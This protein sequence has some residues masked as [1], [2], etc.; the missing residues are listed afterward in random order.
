MI[1][2]EQSMKTISYFTSQIPH[3]LRAAPTIFIFVAFISALVIQNLWTTIFFVG[4]IASC[5]LNGFL[6]DFVARPLYANFNRLS[7]PIIL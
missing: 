5:I 1:L 4:I 3:V 7:L 2:V 6:K